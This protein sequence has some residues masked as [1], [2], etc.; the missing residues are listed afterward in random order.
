M[1]WGDVGSGQP[2]LS[3]TAAMEM[4]NLRGLLNLTVNPILHWNPLQLELA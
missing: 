1:T 3:L 2:F 4:E